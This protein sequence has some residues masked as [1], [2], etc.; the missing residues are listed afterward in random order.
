MPIH[1]KLRRA[2]NR[3]L[4]TSLWGNRIILRL[5]FRIIK[6]LRNFFQ[7]WL[8]PFILLRLLFFNKRSLRH[9]LLNQFKLIRKLELKINAW[10]AY[11]LWL[12]SLPS[13]FVLNYKKLFRNLLVRDILL[14]HHDYRCLVEIWVWIFA[15]ILVVLIVHWLLLQISTSLCF[16]PRYHKRIFTYS[17]IFHFRKHILFISTRI[18]SRIDWFLHPL[19]SWNLLNLRKNRLHVKSFLE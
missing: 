9:W 3:P 12:F 11:L 13:L 10:Q 6:T 19:I 17:W 7:I 8:L 16:L 1:S 18:L 2:S 14:F 15:W 4:D 5:P